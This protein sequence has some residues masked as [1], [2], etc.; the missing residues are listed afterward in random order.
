MGSFLLTRAAVRVVRRIRLIKR[1]IVLPS[2]EPNV[3]P[4]WAAQTARPPPD[5]T[6][7]TR[8]TCLSC[9]FPH[10]LRERQR[11]NGT[12]SEC[13]MCKWGV[14]SFRRSKASLIR[15]PQTL[16]EQAVGML[17]HLMPKLK[18]LEWPG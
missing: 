6:R 18:W 11:W 1:V 12:H 15:N 3:D 8:V 10:L 13:P 5:S 2:P 17:E 4:S 7:K 9:H 16:A 14:Y